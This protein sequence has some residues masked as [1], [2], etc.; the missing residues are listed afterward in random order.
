MNTR[1][2]AI[3]LAHRAGELL[4]DFR[5]EGLAE[6]SIQQKT[7]HFDI[8]TEADVASERLVLDA[9]R[10]AFPEHGFYG[11]ESASGK[12]PDAEWYWLVDPIDGT[13][14]FA[15]GLPIFAVNLALV[16]R[17][18]PVLAVT[19]DPSAHHTYW[20]E[21]G[22]GAWL[23]ASGADQ[24]LAVSSV[25]VL[26]RA[27]LS[28]GFLATRKENPYHNRAE[29]N[30][31][32][33]R[34]QSVRRLGSAALAIA[35]VAAGWLDAYWEQKLKPWDWVPGWLMVAEAGG[36]V[37]EHNNAAARLNSQSLLA[38]NG[39][40]GIH[41]EILETLATVSRENLRLSASSGIL[42]ATQSTEHACT[43][44]GDTGDDANA[45]PG[46]SSF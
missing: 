38:S 21:A 40:R 14:N 5:R 13:T 37:T 17:D 43:S 8:V 22:G 7:S 41:E 25:S 45:H 23:R 31:L 29:F 24:R 42:H 35:W 2:F 10:S 44:T 12:L 16:H 28:T 1:E 18:A 33:L 20:A 3:A 27:L 15:H 4:L 19:H 26:E 32:D 30:A 9:I 6:G 11:E 36:R 46:Q 34:S 39:Q